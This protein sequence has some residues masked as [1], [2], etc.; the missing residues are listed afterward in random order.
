MKKILLIII[1]LFVS[2]SYYLKSQV[3]S[4]NVFLEVQRDSINFT[5]D[6]KLY[7][8]NLVSDSYKIGQVDFTVDSFYPVN[9]N[10]YLYVFKPCNRCE[11][12]L[13]LV[14]QILFTIQGNKLIPSLVLEKKFV[15]SQLIINNKSDIAF[16]DS[17]LYSV[18]Y[19][20]NLDS[21]NNMI[22]YG[23]IKSEQ[24]KNNKQFHYTLKY[25]KKHA[26]YFTDTIRLKGK[27]QVEN[28]N[29]KDQSIYRIFKNKKAFIIQIHDSEY[30]Y[31]DN[32][33][34]YSLRDMKSFLDLHSS[35]SDC[36]YGCFTE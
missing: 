16:G 31:I 28:L 27:F 25:D 36:L 21:I 19:E 35:F 13:F 7:L 33:W 34:Y 30:I 15:S 8:N 18:Y 24:A 14:M 11:E 23:L 5:A 1:I 10:Q 3:L 32:K 12:G 6:I 22:A 26:I 20:I 17:A 9:E 29:R 2:K 4:K